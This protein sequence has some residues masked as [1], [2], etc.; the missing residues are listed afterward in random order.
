MTEQQIA[1]K[2]GMSVA[3]VRSLLASGASKLEHTPTR[4]YYKA[5]WRKESEE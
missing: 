2:L 1:R 5:K 3:E 4:M